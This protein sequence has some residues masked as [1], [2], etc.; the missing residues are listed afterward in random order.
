MR[1]CLFLSMKKIAILTL[2][3]LGVG[4]LFIARFAFPKG[5]A[6]ECPKIPITSSGGQA[7]REV[8]N[9]SKPPEGKEF[10]KHSLNENVWTETK[11]D[12]DADHKPES[13]L[14]ANIAMNH[15][16][17]VLRIV[18]D[19]FVIFKYEGAGVYAAQVDNNDGFILTETLDWNKNLTKQTRYDYDSGKFIPIWYQENCK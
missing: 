4:G 6:K 2:I 16:P 10:Y 3:I 19:N 1:G 11:F 18:K 7:I 8:F 15:T 14:T 9:P 5:I 12:V 13:I 17:H